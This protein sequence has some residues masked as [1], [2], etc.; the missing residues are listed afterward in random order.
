[1]IPFRRRRRSS[2]TFSWP[3]PCNLHSTPATTTIKSNAYFNAEW[4]SWIAGKAPIPYPSEIPKPTAPSIS[5]LRWIIFNRSNAAQARS[6]LICSAVIRNT[7]DSGV[8][9]IRAWRSHSKSPA[10]VS[11]RQGTVRTIE[12]HG[13][14]SSVGPERHLQ[15]GWRGHHR[16]GKSGRFISYP[17]GA[18]TLAKRTMSKEDVR[19]GAVKE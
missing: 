12:E 10:G 1:M 14:P 15:D 6:R 9:R 3:C 8:R 13:E 16:S 18:K 4:I 5:R 17:K 7:L 19:L 2:Q 11:R